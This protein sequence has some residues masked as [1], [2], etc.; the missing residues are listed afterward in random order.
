MPDEPLATPQS[1]ETFVYAL[2]EIHPEIRRSML[3]YIP[4]GA[5]Y[6]R[7]EGMLFFDQD[8]VLCVQEYLNFELGVIE[9]YGYEVS[10][11][12][13]SLSDAPFPGTAEYCR[14]GF[15]HKDKLY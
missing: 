9:G 2:P 1:Y 11:P 3:V 15:P 12:H 10:Q 6:G 14:P 7:V 13:Q 5:F 8:V 4:S